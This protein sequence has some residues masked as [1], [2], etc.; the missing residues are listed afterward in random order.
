MATR[1]HTVKGTA[2]WAKVFDHN[3]ELKDWQGNPHPFGG[4]FK[5][6]VIL[7]KTQRATYKASGTAGKGKFDDDGNFIATFKRKEKEKFD[8]AGGPP[9]VLN[10][11]STP[12]TGTVVPN[13]SEVEVEFSVYT[14]S[15]SNGTRLESVRILKLEEMP[16]KK[17]EAA[18][19][20]PKPTKTTSG[21]VY[22]P[23]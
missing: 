2:M 6:D 12:F 13:G 18:P 8:W 7:D 4:L 11:D 21:E 15:M 14:T 23:F 20:P 19:E 1:K 16:E 9:K 22:V 17:P 10:A 3:K 5:I